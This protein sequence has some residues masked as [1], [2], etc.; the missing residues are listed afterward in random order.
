MWYLSIYAGVSAT[1]ILFQLSSTLLLKV[2]SLAAARTMHNDMLKALLRLDMVSLL[3]FNLGVF[4]NATS[5]LCCPSICAGV[6]A[7]EIMFQFSSTLLLKMLSLAAARTMHN[8]MLAAQ[9][10]V[11]SANVHL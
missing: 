6:L 9:D 3:W 5:A 1:Q 11:S 7:T 10:C 8:D 2:L 4:V